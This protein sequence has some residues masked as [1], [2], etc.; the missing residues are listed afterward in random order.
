LDF[1]I[2]G[3]LLLL[4]IIGWLARSGDRSLKTHAAVPAEVQGKFILLLCGCSSRDDIENA[5]ILDREGDGYTF[6]V[7]GFRG[8]CIARA[9]LTGEEALRDA[10]QFL[11]CNIHCERSRLIKILGPQGAAAGFALMPL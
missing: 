5:A 10:E 3:I 2:P 1:L 9:G 4:I 6:E 7:T 11:R 8:S